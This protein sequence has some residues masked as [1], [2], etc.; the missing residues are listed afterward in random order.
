MGRHLLGHKKLSVLGVW[1]TGPQR[2]FPSLGENEAS[3]SWWTCSKKQQQKPAANF[4]NQK[5]EGESDATPSWKGEGFKSNLDFVMFVFVNEGSEAE[6]SAWSAE[7]GQTRSRTGGNPYSDHVWEAGPTVTF[8]SNGSCTIL[9][10]RLLWLLFI[11][12]Y[13]R[14]FRAKRK[15]NLSNSSAGYEAIFSNA[16]YLNF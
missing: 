9:K 15:A 2:S 5:N 6:P 10:N 3:F 1:A 8:R 12:I 11:F 4:K 7:C 14:V 16:L 13:H